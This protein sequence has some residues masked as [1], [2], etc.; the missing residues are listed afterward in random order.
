MNQPAVDRCNVCDHSYAQ[1]C[2]LPAAI[3]RHLGMVRAAGVYP[4]GSVLC[5]ESQPAR[6]VYIICAG[7]AK[8]YTRARDG[9][10]V[11]L[12]LA[13][14]GDMVGLAAV[15][16]SKVHA[17]TVETLEPTRANFI[18]SEDFLRLLRQDPQ[19]GMRVA[20]QLTGDL[21]LAINGLRS[22]GL[23]ETVPQRIARMLIEWIET[24]EHVEPTSGDVQI[25]VPYTQEE[26]AQMIGSTRETVSRTL[27]AFRRAGVLQIKGTKWTIL[28]PKSIYGLII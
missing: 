16:A 18:A 3:A 15:V 11:V 22:L 8:A 25:A 23:S 28:D 10:A 20:H 27:N 4:K 19:V 2:R 26:I 12:G 1:A 13:R 6:G 7:R 21:H 5:T 17:T 24:R 14:P 9:R